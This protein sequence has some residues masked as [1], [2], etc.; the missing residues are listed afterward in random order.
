MCVQ[1]PGT[2]KLPNTPLLVIPGTNIG[3]A[4][5]SGEHSIRLHC[6]PYR[7]FGYDT[8]LVEELSACG[9][10]SRCDDDDFRMFH[11]FLLC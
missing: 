2:P 6:L 9:L 10:S 7:D 3:D 1:A 8:V 5:I 11:S 4:D